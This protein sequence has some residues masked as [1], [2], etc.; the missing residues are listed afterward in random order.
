L[1]ANTFN[2]KQVSILQNFFS[3]LNHKADQTMLDTFDKLKQNAEFNRVNKWF[4]KAAETLVLK[5]HITVHKSFWRLKNNAIGNMAA[6]E[7]ENFKT[8]L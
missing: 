1:K 4:Y 7:K 5:S 3:D 2:F 6:Y 8:K